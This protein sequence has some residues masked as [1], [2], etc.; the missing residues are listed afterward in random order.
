MWILKLIFLSFTAASFGCA[1][2][3]GYL[4]LISMIGIVPRLASTSKT[5]KYVLH[6]ENA[7]IYGAVTGNLLYCYP[8]ILRIG[9]VIPAAA[10]LF[11]GVFVGCLA[12]A[13]AEVVNVL[14]IFARRTNLRKGIPYIIYALG[15]GKGV[16]VLAQFFIL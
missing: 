1:V 6:Y 12:G 5:G 9:P 11:S 16:G 7:L 2:A 4:A 13:L 14:P 8:I 10:G 3:G 15:F